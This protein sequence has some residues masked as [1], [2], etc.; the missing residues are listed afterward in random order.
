ME[1]YNYDLLREKVNNELETRNKERKVE[2][3]KQITNAQRELQERLG[4]ADDKVLRQLED[5]KN[6]AE[7]ERKKTATKDLRE[8]ALNL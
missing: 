3:N 7:V 6:L 5:K 2:I 4:N 1:Q 8:E